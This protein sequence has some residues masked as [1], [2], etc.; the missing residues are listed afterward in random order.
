MAQLTIADVSQ[1]YR[2]HDETMLA[3]DS[4]SMDAKVGEFVCIVGP[5]GCGKSTL[6]K[7]IADIQKPS[8]GQIVTEAD[9]AYVPQ[10]SSL[11]PWRTVRENISL[12]ALL[13]GDPEEITLK[14]VNALLREFK[15]S[16]FADHYPSALSGG[17]QQK[18]SLL[19]AIITKPQLLLLD[20][21]FA[22]LDA[23]T[24]QTLQDWL[25]E[26][27][28]EEKPTIV[29]VTHDIREALALADTIYVLSTRPG[30]IIKKIDIGLVRPRDLTATKAH[31]IEAELR[32]LLQT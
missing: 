31:Q 22:W 14:R 11:L 20:E 23:L 27:W 7:L 6:L 30:R 10:Q 16:K 15:L 29:C 28:Q 12:P 17:M 3:L 32:E 2:K 21:P 13:K 26:L 19:R 5:N 8:S 18:V 25:I 24:R 1:Q 4:V 9:I